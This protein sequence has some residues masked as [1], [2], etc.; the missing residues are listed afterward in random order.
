MSTVT[1]YGSSDDLIEIEG[2]IQEEF[3]WQ[4]RGEESRFIA[5]SDGTVLECKYDGFWRFT[6]R[7]R[8]TASMTKVEATDVD[9]DY[10]DRVTLTGDVRWAVVGEHYV[11][12][13]STAEG[14]RG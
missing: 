14:R 4:S 8:G 2:D 6:L 7:S 10:S 11:A 12:K 1:V 9:T 13:R 5:F 3:G